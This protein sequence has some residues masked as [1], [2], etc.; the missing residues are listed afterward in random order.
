MEV[1][2]AS[3]QGNRGYQ[4]DRVVHEWI[5]CPSLQNGTGWLLA[6]FD[7]HN[8]AKTA[9]MVS[10]AFPS[11]FETYLLAQRGDAVKALREVFASLNQMVKDQTSG[12]TASVAFIPQD[13]QHIILAVLGDSPI[14]VQDATGSFYYRS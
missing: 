11:L 2:I 4:E 5:S 8:G 14:A 9:D 3:A 13:A 12:S 6:V 7:G 10:K 1:S